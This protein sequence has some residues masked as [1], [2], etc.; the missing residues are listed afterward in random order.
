MVQDFNLTDAKTT[1]DFLFQLHNLASLANGND[2][3]QQ[4]FDKLAKLALDIKALQFRTLTN[5]S[6]LKRKARNDDGAG[7]GP[8]KKRGMEGGHV[9]SDTLFDVAI[10][11]ELERAGYT[12]PPEVE[13]FESLLPVRVLSVRRAAIDPTLELTAKLQR[14]VSAHGER[15][16]LKLTDEH[17]VEVLRRLHGDQSTE[18]TRIIP[19]LDVVGRRVMVLPLRTPLSHFLALDASGDDVE[20]LAQQF[21]EGVAYLQRC[22]VAHLDLKPDNIVVQRDA[23]SM[24]MDLAI[25]DF[26]IS[27]FADAEPTISGSSGTPGWLA[28]EV[29]AGKSY[30]PLLADRWSC[31]RVLEFFTGCMKPSRL[32]ERMYL[33]SQRLMNPNPSLRP[34]VLDVYPPKMRE[35]LKPS[36]RV[37]E[38][39]PGGAPRLGSRNSRRLKGLGPQVYYQPTRLK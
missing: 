34:P 19:L 25:I 12:I 22:S 33:S 26:N 3:L 39:R 4:P 21:L 29:S 28:P 17:E 11:E 7:N 2:T 32:R 20:Q 16:I 1:F 13:N 9:E 35:A 8:F 36:I 27:V 18:Q 6:S 31:G 37:R 23:E 24:K 15:V 5:I 30:N 10:L 38:S 14:A